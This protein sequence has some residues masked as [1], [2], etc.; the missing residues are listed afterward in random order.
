MSM[1]N[2]SESVEKA[3][4]EIKDFLSSIGKTKFTDYT[5]DFPDD[6]D[7]DKVEN[8]DNAENV[9]MLGSYGSVGSYWAIYTVVRRIKVKKN[10]LLFDV[11]EFYST[12]DGGNMGIE[13][14]LYKDI[15]VNK[16]IRY[17]G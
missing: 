8:L 2:L 12:I 7:E 5:S 17:C 16:L 3:C 11:E 10:V 14:E 13:P 9:S 4:T 15:S 6:L 1:L